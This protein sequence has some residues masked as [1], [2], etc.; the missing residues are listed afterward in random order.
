MHATI[1][2]IRMAAG[3]RAA[4]RWERTVGRRRGSSA[5]ALLAAWSLLLQGCYESTPL[6]Q[7]TPPATQ[8]VELVLNDKGRVAVQDK[9]GPRVDK[10][11]GMV[12]SE[13][14]SSYTMSVYH[15]SQLSGVGSTFSGQQVAIDKD[16]TTGFQLRRINKTRTVLLA[17]GVVV[18][19]VAIF[20]KTLNIGGGGADTP[21]AEVPPK[22]QAKVGR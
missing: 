22:G 20:G 7:G 4:R 11:E 19:V 8:R 10:V 2:S 12:V 17:G 16:G 21:P 5:G 15:V 14:E 6:E 9:L 18:G 1:P 3:S 13:S